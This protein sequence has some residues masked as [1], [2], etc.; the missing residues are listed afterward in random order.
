MRYIPDIPTSVALQVPEDKNSYINIKNVGATGEGDTIFTGTVT[1]IQ[2]DIITI[3]NLPPQ[4]LLK[5]NLDIHVFSYRTPTVTDT[6]ILSVTT[7]IPV[8]VDFSSSPV[9]NSS[10]APLTYYVFGF[11]PQ[12]G[13]LPNYR[14]TVVVGTKVLDPE[15]WNLDQYVQLNFTRTSQYALPVIY[16]VWGTRIDFLGVIGNNK[17]GYPGSGSTAFRDLGLTEIPSWDEEKSL[18]WFL[19]GV[20]S[21]SNNVVSVAK[22]LTGKHKLTILPA[23]TGTQPSYIQCSGLPL[24]AQTEFNDEVK[25][26]IDDTKFVQTAINLASTGGIKEVFF[27]A[28]TYNLTDTFF[29]N[30]SGVSLTGSGTSSVLKRLPATLGNPTYPGLLNFTGE[31]SIS[32]LKISSLSFDGNSQETYSAVSP[33][34]T[35]VGLQVENTSNLSVADC[36]FTNFGGGGISLV[37]C[38]STS[39]FSNRVQF[40]G[41]SYEQSVSPLIVENCENLVAQG[42][43]FEYATTS[44]K[45]LSTDY[46][47]INSNIVR[48][49]GD[50]GI[51]LG[52]SYQWNAQGNLAYSDNDS[53][54]RS[55]DTY[56]NEYSRATI[57]VRKGYA[58]DPVFM[59]V[60][61][62]GESVS[63]IKNTI[64][65]DIYG[66][67]SSG[68]KVTPAIGSFR[69]LETADQLEAGIFS[70]TLPA[71]VS[72]S[73]GGKTIPATASLSNSN[74]YVYEVKADV[75][76]GREFQPVSIRS[77]TISGDTYLAI[78]LRNSSDLLSFQIYSSSHPENDEI[79]ISGYSNTGLGI[80]QGTS[81]TVLGIDS[82]TNSLLI[83]E[84]SG[85]NPTSP[86]V[87][88]GNPVLQILRPDYFVADGNLYVHTF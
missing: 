45:V 46:S 84:I 27:P 26:V 34:T 63:I 88:L 22:K 64:S 65:A 76:M 25:F 41:R 15:L 56:N 11:D 69:V 39:L 81:Y 12:T 85:F 86:I 6:P 20:F 23:P 28:G 74:G 31:P 83:D 67:N 9:S 5:S 40:T 33:I 77:L 3:S 52:T 18:P 80:S 14:S 29:L 24:T 47:T 87:F 38:D 1:D 54:I 32:G 19:S 2:E 79:V 75:L 7:H 43:V 82:D 62:G 37:G 10:L 4:T 13:I 35:E 8:D 30:T 71:T 53:L 44:P 58:L 17:V 36:I 72:A 49:C 57:E 61:M 48:S 50:K 70:L 60:T 42:N 16:R 21:I 66:L 51:Q 73:F 68:V 55:I 59:T 78:Q